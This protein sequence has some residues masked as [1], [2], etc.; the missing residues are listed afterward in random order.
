VI[1]KIAH[2]GI[3]VK[4]LK[5]ASE[6]YR[7]ILHTEPSE[8]EFVAE[9][10][11]NVVKFKVGDATIELLEGTSTE[12]AI[13]RFIQNRGE[14]IHHISYESN[15]INEEMN[16]LKKEGFELVYD[17]PKTGSDNSLITFLRPAKT[18]GVLTEISQHKSE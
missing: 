14:G 8:K 18:N 7:K 5:T 2:I 11:V 10:S 12:S 16:R 17:E 13:S 6:I 9:Q 4:N 1:T 3:A 15:D